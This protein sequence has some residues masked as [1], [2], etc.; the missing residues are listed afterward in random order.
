MR[1]KFGDLLRRLRE[2][3]DKSM[4]GLARHLGYSVPYVS[5]VE[6][7]NRAPFAPEK[8]VEA[9]AYLGVPAQPLL[10]AAIESRGS[11]EIDVRNASPRAM[12]VGAALM[13][14]FQDLDE[15]ALEK[16]AAILGNGG[17]K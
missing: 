14:G 10:V 2:E 13:R 5:D 9:A 7:G 16:L 4:G 11:F 17:K 12:E 15:D 8:I 6:R 3:K 1:E